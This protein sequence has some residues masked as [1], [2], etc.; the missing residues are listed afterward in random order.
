MNILIINRITSI[1]KLLDNDLYKLVLA[2]GKDW[3]GCS[4]L[5]ATSARVSSSQVA[6]RPDSV[7]TLHL[8]PAALMATTLSPDNPRGTALGWCTF[9]SCVQENKHDEFIVKFN[10]LM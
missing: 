3:A 5:V 9:G 8:T 2:S 6:T 4:S 7:A 10:A 1:S